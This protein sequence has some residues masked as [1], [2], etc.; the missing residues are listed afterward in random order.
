MILNR[1]FVAVRATGLLAAVLTFF[2]SYPLAAQVPKLVEQ[3]DRAPSVAKEGLLGASIVRFNEAAAQKLLTSEPGE[4]PRF[5]IDLAPGMTVDATFDRRHEIAGAYVWEGSLTFDPDAS[6]F[7]TRMGDYTLIRAQLTDGRIFEVQSTAAGTYVGGEVDIGIADRGCSV[8]PGS[9]GGREVS[10]QSA[11]LPSSPAVGADS[12]AGPTTYPPSTVDVLVVYSTAARQAALSKANIESAIVTAVAQMNSALTASKVPMQV[13]LV[14][15]AEYGALPPPSPQPLSYW[16][17]EMR[18]GGRLESIRSG[19]ERYRAD[20]A[21]LVVDGSEA[22]GECGLANMRDGRPA[23]QREA[24]F[25]VVVRQ[26]L[27]AFSLAHELG[28]NFGLEHDRANR[29]S[30]PAESFAYGYQDPSGAFRTIM[31]YADGCP[32]PCPRVGRFSNADILFNGRPLGVPIGEAQEADNAQALANVVREVAAYAHGVDRHAYCLNPV[33]LNSVVDGDFSQPC[34]SI[35]KG[36][37]DNSAYYTFQLAAETW[38]Q[39]KGSS[40]AGMSFILRAGASRSGAEVTSATGTR[41]V[42]AEIYRRLPAGDY[43]VEVTS[44]WTPFYLAVTEGTGPAVSCQRSLQLGERM[45]T[46]FGVCNSHRFDFNLSTPTAVTVEINSP[47][48]A[49]AYAIDGARHE[50]AAGEDAA[51]SLYLREGSHQLVVERIAT[52][53]SASPLEVLVSSVNIDPLSVV[54]I[55]RSG[56]GGA[57]SV[58]ASPEGGF[59]SWRSFVSQPDG[60]GSQTS[61]AGRQYQG[62]TEHGMFMDLGGLAFDVDGSLLV[63]DRGAYTI[64]R[65]GRD[66]TVTT[67]AGTT[68]ESGERDGPLLTARFRDPID[69]AVGRDG[70]IYVLDNGTRSV[71]KIAGGVVSHLFGFPSVNGAR[72]LAVDA[73]NRIYVSVDRRILRWDGTLTEFIGAVPMDGASYPSGDLHLVE[74]AGMA[75]APNGDMYIADRMGDRLRRVDFGAPMTGASRWPR[76]VVVAGGGNEQNGAWRDVNLFLVEDVDVAPDGTIYI[77]DAN[78]LKKAVRSS[79][80]S[81]APDPIASITVQP[82]ACS[83]L[84]SSEARRVSFG[85]NQPGYTRQPCDQIRWTFGDGGQSTEW[86]PVHRFAAAGSYLVRATITNALSAGGVT[87]TRTVN[88]G[89]TI[90][91]STLA[92]QAQRTGTVN[93]FADSGSA[94]F[95]GDTVRFNATSMSATPGSITWSFD[96]GPLATQEASAAQSVDYRY[97]AVRG[98][99]TTQS[100]VVTARMSADV[101]DCAGTVVTL[102]VPRQRFYLQRNGEL[103]LLDPLTPAAAHPG[104]AIVDG[105]DGTIESHTNEWSVSGGESFVTTPS[106]SV[107]ISECG[108]LLYTVDSTYGRSEQA[109]GFAADTA[110]RIWSRPFSVALK[111]TITRPGYVAVQPVVTWSNTALM[112]GGATTARWEWSTVR[113]NGTVVGTTWITTGPLSSTDG[114]AVPLTELSGGSRIQ[115][116][117]SVDPTAGRFASCSPSLTQTAVYLFKTPAPVINLEGCLEVGSPCRATAVSADGLVGEWKDTYISWEVDGIAAGTTPSIEITLREKRAHAVRVVASNDVGSQAV[118]TVIFPGGECSGTAPQTGNTA[119]NHDCASCTNGVT[120]TFSAVSS[121]VDDCAA[122]RWEFGDGS[123]S[124]GRIATHLYSRPGRYVVRAT[125]VNGHG[126]S[127]TLRTVDVLPRTVY[128]DDP[129]IPRVTAVRAIHLVELRAAVNAARQRAGLGAYTWSQTIVAGVSIKGAHINELRTALDPAL[130][131]IGV[132][133]AYTDSGLLSANTVIRAAHIQELR[134]YAR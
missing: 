37:F 46:W 55:S 45:K 1:V 40:I 104:D 98:A 44:A 115:L 108:A 114:F 14:L 72:G 36:C 123:V 79:S 122:I 64:R 24:A 78:G 77:A 19:R 130:S 16:L 25:S 30:I 56:W 8:E 132:T 116:V 106:A 131:A 112:L 34:P 41:A 35:T 23:C 88:V 127:S 22:P 74:P 13:E 62:G 76:T 90:P 134:D 6:V 5:T 32:A 73:L 107:P 54:T 85:V 66:G 67:F 81:T 31:A 129:L 12:Y 29:K 121:Q 47:M 65:V 124:Y 133:P 94:I 84:P 119:I 39:V 57:R 61:L 42:P 93:P 100:R 17:G 28:H 125:E 80:C 117:V 70:T 26:C 111:Q 51:I 33:A 120:V 103:Q 97:W 53:R 3:L 87:L 68:M 60:A 69:V 27:A 109:G 95:F 96:D 126:T 48:D 83:G 15:L 89:T 4:I 113:D 18:A 10:A 58:A 59:G 91:S 128:A 20:L 38:V 82:Y 101:G 105:S 52:G 9:P 86:N 63:A 7:L 50:L 118:S 92:V 110:Y 21:M 75:F 71:R 11:D 49:V 102:E 43:T 99:A 2:G